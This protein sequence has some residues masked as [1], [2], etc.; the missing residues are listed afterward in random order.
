MK[1]LLHALYISLVMSIPSGCIT[2]GVTLEAPP[3]EEVG[4]VLRLRTPGGYSSPQTRS[5][6]IADENTIDDDLYVLVFDNDSPSRLTSV[7]KAEDV[8]DD[9]GS[10]SGS[11]SVTLPPSMGTQASTLVVLANSEEILHARGVID[12]G[13]PE[14]PSGFI[15]RTYAEV[16]SSIWDRFT[17]P[18]YSEGGT[19]PMWGQTPP[20]V[21]TPANNDQSVKLT[22]AL[23]RV[24]V[25][26]GA[27]DGQTWSGQ[28][29][30]GHDIPFEL[31]EVYVVRP[32]DRYSA[33]PTSVNDQDRVTAPTVPTGTSAYGATDESS[34]RRFAYTD[35]TP[36]GGS[37]G[38]Y[39]TRSIYLPEA[40]IRMDAD[41]PAQGDANHKNRMALV[42]GGRYAGA[43]TSTFYRVDF[44][45]GEAGLI[46]VLRNHLY[47]INISGVSGEGHPTVK[48]AYEASSMEMEVDILE[49]NEGLDSEY[50]F[51]GIYFFGMD[52]GH[53]EFSALGD[54]TEQVRIHTNIP[55][56]SMTL[57]EVTLAANG[58]TSWDGSPNYSYSLTKDGQET[59]CL[60]IRSKNNNVSK[61]A[62]TGR[63]EA[64]SVTAKRIKFPFTVD[65]SWSSTYVSV[66]NGD[67]TRVWPEGTDSETIPVD[68]LSSVPV[69]VTGAPSWITIGNLP[70]AGF[71]EAHLAIQVAPFEYGADGTDNRTA[72]LIIQVQ[73][74][75]PLEYL[76]IQEAPYLLVY[77]PEV[78]VPR[79]DEAKIVVEPVQIQTNLPSG[80]LDLVLGQGSDNGWEKI[81]KFSTAHPGLYNAGL[82][83]RPRY[84]RFDVTV[85]LETQPVPANWFSRPFTVSVRSAGGSVPD[86]GDIE[87]VNGTVIVRRGEKIFDFIW[88][89]GMF[90]GDGLDDPSWVAPAAPAEPDATQDYIFPWNAQKIELDILSNMGLAPEDLTRQTL[91][92]G[93][94][95]VH[96]SSLDGDTQITPLTFNFGTAN[97]STT[98]QYL[99]SFTPLYSEGEVEIAFSQSAQSWSRGV[100]SSEW[101]WAGTGAASDSHSPLRVTGNIEWEAAVTPSSATWLSV[102]TGGGYAASARRT[103]H[104]TKPVMSTGDMTRSGD[105][106]IHIAPVATLN[107]GFTR[108]SATVAFTNLDSDTGGTGNL[109]LSDPA[110]PGAPN[111]VVVN[112]YAPT[113]ANAT[114]IPL[115]NIAVGGSTSYQIAATTNLQ[116][117]GVKTFSTT[118]N[119]GQEGTRQQI[120]SVQYYPGTPMLSASALATRSTMGITV[121]PYAG[122]VDRTLEFVLCSSEFPGAADIP[123]GTAVQVAAPNLSIY[124]TT[125]IVSIWG[126]DDVHSESVSVTANVPWEAFVSSG[127][128]FTVNGGT[129]TITGE[130]NGSFT[131]APQ[132]PNGVT[133]RT[134]TITIRGREGNAGLSTT[135]TLNQTAATPGI[136]VDRA[137]LVP[138]DH[139]DTSTN[140]QTFSLTSNVPWEIAKTG[141][142]AGYDFTVSPS[143]GDPGENI[144]ITLRPS[145][146]NLRGDISPQVT[147][148]V[149]GQSSYAHI[150]AP[151]F[152]V[153]QGSAPVKWDVQIDNALDWE[154]ADTGATKAKTITVT[155]NVQWHATKVENP[156]GTAFALAGTTLG[157]VN[158]A[159]TFTVYPSVNSGEG[160]KVTVTVEG[161]GT[162]AGI[163]GV[164]TRTFEI[165]QKPAPRI[166]ISPTSSTIATW[167][168]N[169]TNSVT[170]SVSSNIPWEAVV[171]SGSGFTIDGG[172]TASGEN[173]GSFNVAPQGL[174]GVSSR[175]MTITI[176]GRGIYSAT[177]TTLT[178]NQT[179][180]APSLTIPGTSPRVLWA[181]TE[182]GALNVDVTSNVTW[183]AS[184]PAGSGF[185]LSNN[186]NR[187]PNSNFTI[188]PDSTNSTFTARS[189]TVTVA[190]SSGGTSTVKTITVT[191]AAAVPTLEITNTNNVSWTATDTGTKDV[192]VSSNVT[193]TASISSGSGFVLSNNTNR[194]PGSFFTI[195][196]SSANNA[197]N[198][199]RSVEITVTGSSGGTSTV[200]TI[201]LSQAGVPPSLEIP[202][203]SPR[204][205]WD[206]NSTTRTTVAVTSNVTWN[207]EIT[208]GDT[209]YFTLTNNT[210]RGP[211]STFSIQ[212]TGSN[213]DLAARSVTITVTGTQGG[214]TT[215]KSVTVT[216][217]GRPL[218]VTFS[219]QRWDSTESD[220]RNITVTTNGTSWSAAMTG[221]TSYFTLTNN[222]NR[223][224]GDYFTLKPTTA[225]TTTTVRTVTVTVTATAGSGV[226]ANTK[227]FG[228]TFTQELQG[229]RVGNLIW[230]PFDDPAGMVTSVQ[231]PLS[232]CTN[233][234]RI[235]TLAEFANYS[236]NNLRA[237]A[238]YWTTNT[239]S[240]QNGADYLG[241]NTGTRSSVYVAGASIAGEFPGSAYVRCVR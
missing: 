78:L 86:Y 109:D 185:T 190:G 61:I 30:E 21:I 128:G 151:S 79:P 173:N 17:A 199:P 54:Q 53:V 35:I 232:N 72:R 133:A 15:G 99:L 3:A 100:F 217:A 226:N 222:T 149:K 227:E 75:P 196:P 180:A 115:P 93:F 182:S 170:V 39:I 139:D 102:S 230:Y 26:V 229:I 4:L 94:M 164:T 156:A 104:I 216:Q 105:M 177:S 16:I 22:R 31:T 91:H 168:P 123:I 103:D 48:E 194:G 129:T 212:P 6:S 45:T 10:G 146:A 9:Q 152:T 163:G 239:N 113:L 12:M 19:I 166:S 34:A 121:P 126:P 122:L 8:D 62:T 167:A 134:M 148:T 70:P 117:W 158:N 204:E 178:L 29:A 71:L 82:S 124:P 28:D 11:F 189:V 95:E 188:K 197:V 207:A 208:G 110:P 214:D 219:S 49:W 98:R 183:T 127:G 116:G 67:V 25:G 209:G 32:N 38:S 40:D 85:D 42:V 89:S 114:S 237:N 238:V 64:W 174:N 201:T 41:T 235:P 193:W 181:A 210:N 140:Y 218:T 137:A 169:T 225:N 155:S 206:Y 203:D 58:T 52:P 13:D 50:H 107:P 65:Q 84:V 192:T 240:H 60:S 136:S 142:T 171:N 159:S 2:D 211:S 205:L 97:R 57:G 120:G 92:S 37:T 106:N 176:R 184:I 118:S 18:L 5:L 77:P 233:P 160:R 165:A 101:G 87:P 187:G 44:A 150:A 215:K 234:W 59:Y 90:V 24:D 51:D 1:K 55:D 33:I 144:Q 111:S 47:R 213:P 76:I 68:I 81:T 154:A 125:D 223:T 198:T 162:G 108:R 46:D 220:A 119:N 224:S 66:S 14:T 63:G 186:T 20:I 141:A 96:P 112:Q 175:S 74:E 36:S 132:G 23:A 80:H 153:S 195:R 83:Q 27:P 73:G 200:K 7:K 172:T 161:T 231:P 221:D 202:G 157:T 135:L 143:Y 43:A 88:R 130:N 138:F 179:A 228:I 145:A 56:F 236:P 147:L 131:V 191:Q 241:W 69:T